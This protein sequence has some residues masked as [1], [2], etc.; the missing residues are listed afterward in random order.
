MRTFRPPHTWHLLLSVAGL[1]SS[2]GGDQPKT[3]IVDS[4]AVPDGETRDAEAPPD[5]A[6]GYSSWDVLAEV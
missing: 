6:A 2:C 3:P 1:L 4:G 5:D